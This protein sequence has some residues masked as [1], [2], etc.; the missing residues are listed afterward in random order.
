M[1]VVQVLCGNKCD[2]EED[3]VV[4]K[5]DG[6]RLAKR[7]GCPFFETSAKTQ[8]NVEEAIHELVRRTPRYSKEYKLVIMGSGGV[9]KS[10]ICL[11]YVQG[12]FVDEYDPTI[13]DSYRKQCVIHGI[14]EENRLNRVAKKKSGQPG[15]LQRLLGLSGKSK[16]KASCGKKVRCQKMDCN[17]VAVQ[18][19][20]LEEEPVLATGDP[21]FCQGCN[22]VLSRI[23]KLDETKKWRWYVALELDNPCMYVKAVVFCSEFCGHVNDELDVIPEEVQESL[24]SSCIENMYYLFL[25]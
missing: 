20:L 22:V 5:A 19:G 8:L 7:I 18:L 25:F 12:H 21:V 10:A 11:Q 6:I 16:E 3:R 14:P 9:G 1:F 17:V 2:L 24:R 4:S 23:S 15:R 13:E